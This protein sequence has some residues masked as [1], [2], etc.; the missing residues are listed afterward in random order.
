[1]VIPC[2]FCYPACELSGLTAPYDNACIQSLLI[3]ESVFLLSPQ[4]LSSQR[5][6][7]KQLICH[8]VLNSNYF[9]PVQQNK[10]IKGEETVVW[11]AI[12]QGKPI[13]LHGCLNIGRSKQQTR[14]RINSISRF[15]GRQIRF[16]FPFLQTGVWV[17]Y[18][19]STVLNWNLV[20]GL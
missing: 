2:G 8:S 15:F 18:L 14:A 20:Q 12:S 3:W 10:I 19:D 13:K 7:F 17:C 6:D 4:R 9:Y 16:N 5:K 11:F 1:M